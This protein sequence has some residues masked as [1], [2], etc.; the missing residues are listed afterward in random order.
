MLPNRENVLR[1]LARLEQEGALPQD[2]STSVFISA[3]AG[4]VRTHA[5][6]VAV[7]VQGDVVYARISRLPFVRPMVFTRQALREVRL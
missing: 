3:R 7:R 4:L 1:V 6:Q 2:G 5:T